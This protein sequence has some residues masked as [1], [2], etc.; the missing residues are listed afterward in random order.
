[1]AHVIK[2]YFGSLHGIYGPSCPNLL[3]RHCLKCSEVINVAIYPCTKPSLQTLLKHLINTMDGQE[4]ADGVRARG[5][6]GSRVHS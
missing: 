5:T 2:W 1:M 6:P 3:F 4:G